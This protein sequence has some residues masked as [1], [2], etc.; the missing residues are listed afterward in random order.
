MTAVRRQRIAPNCA[1]ELRRIIARRTAR[2][3]EV[4]GEH[5]R[6]LGRLLRGERDQP[7]PLRPSDLAGVVHGDQ[8]AVACGARGLTNEVEL[9]FW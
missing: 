3:R 9:K 1:E 5:R 6:E 4:L 2:G 7:A 8:D